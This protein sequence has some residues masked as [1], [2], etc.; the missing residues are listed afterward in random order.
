MEERLEVVPL[1][2]QHPLYTVVHNIILHCNA[3]PVEAADGSKSE[4]Y[5]PH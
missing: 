4:Q 1:D 3:I 2:I 5:E